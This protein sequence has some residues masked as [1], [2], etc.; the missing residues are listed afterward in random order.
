MQN[1]APPEANR[2]ASSRAPLARQTRPNG[3]VA[4]ALLA[5]GVGALALAIL[6]VASEA[7][8]AFGVSL[9]YS[10]AVGPL[11]GKA[12]WAVVAFFGSW[13]LLA[14]AFRK[15]SVNLGTIAV[16]ACVLI[17]LALVGTFAPFFQL[18]APE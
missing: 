2:P 18:F 14:A 10:E 8:E 17:G 15:R 7:S 5:T 4:A 13:L 12:I 6:V 16:I 11:A 1:A 9:A 3:P